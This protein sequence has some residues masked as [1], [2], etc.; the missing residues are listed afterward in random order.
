[1]KFSPNPKKKDDKKK[2]DIRLIRISEKN[3]EKIKALSIKTKIA[4]NNLSDEIFNVFF[5]DIDVRKKVLDN[6]VKTINIMINNQ[7]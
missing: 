6:I 5:D 3:H 1:M 2:D 4:I 7:E